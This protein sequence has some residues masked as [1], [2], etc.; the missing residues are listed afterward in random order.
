MN[1]A[2]FTAASA[3][4]VVTGVALAQGAEDPLAQL[5]TC[6]LMQR[7][8]RVQCL[9]KLARSVEPPA[10]PTT[11]VSDWV[12]SL[13]TS[14]VD[15]TPIATATT[16]SGEVA[17]GSPL[18]LTMRCRGGR[19]ELAVSGPAISGRAEDYVVSYSTKGGQPVQIAAATPAFGTGIA[20]KVDP[21]ALFQS[22]PSD[23]ELVVYIASRLGAAQHG[24]FSL[25]GLEAVRTKI[26]MAC[27]WPAAIA[28]PNS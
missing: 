3:L 22:L 20:F 5:R 4:A 2:I 16:A 27:K 7:E 8:D 25:V 13:T 28:K 11:A 15:Y 23:G 19:S 10:G 12:I 1:R 26:A 18:Q 21:S 6:N 17:G 9:D 14:P 24:T